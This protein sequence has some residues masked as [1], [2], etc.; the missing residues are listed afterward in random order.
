[1]IFSLGFER[2]SAD[3]LFATTKMLGAIV[4]DVRG[5]PHRH[6]CGLGRRQLKMALGDRYVWRDDLG[7][8]GGWDSG[9][10]WLL[11]QRQSVIVLCCKEAPAECHRHDL[12]IASHQYR[13]ERGLPFVEMMHIY[14]DIVFRAFDMQRAIDTGRD[15]YP[16]FALDAIVASQRP[17]W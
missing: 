11:S 10:A 5:N 9:I 1:M 6:K 12:L 16:L 17:S 2:L 8:S 7:P 3:E 14:R 4:A 15:D 13:M